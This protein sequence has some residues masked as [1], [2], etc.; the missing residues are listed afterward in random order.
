MAEI[1]NLRQARKQRGRADKAQTAADNRARHGRTKGE[2]ERDSTTRSKA[3][4]DLDAHRLDGPDRTDD[5]PDEPPPS[6]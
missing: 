3:E 4:R 2:R 1:I 5:P 6:A